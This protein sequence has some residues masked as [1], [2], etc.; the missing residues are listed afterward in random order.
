[1]PA[2]MTTNGNLSDASL[3]RFHSVSKNRAMSPSDTVDMESPL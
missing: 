3:E 2:R 1:V